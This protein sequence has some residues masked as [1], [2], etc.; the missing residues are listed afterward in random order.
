MAAQ[1]NCTDVLNLISAYVDGELSPSLCQ[2]IEEH[3]ATCRN[4]YVVFDSMSKTLALY[5]RLEP[6]EM[7]HEVEVRL[8]RVLNLDDFITE[9]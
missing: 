8:F 6:P 2:A 9:R 1:L 3:L 4:C 5:H 7:P